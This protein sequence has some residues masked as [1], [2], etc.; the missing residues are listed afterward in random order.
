MTLC[1]IF[2]TFCVMYWSC[3]WITS[4]SMFGSGCEC[5]RMSN[6]EETHSLHLYFAQLN[7]QSFCIDCLKRRLLQFSI[8]FSKF[9]IKR[10][11]GKRW[12]E[13]WWVDM[14]S[15][16]WSGRQGFQELQEPFSEWIDEMIEG[17]R[18]VTGIVIQV[19][20]SL[21]RVREVWQAEHTKLRKLKG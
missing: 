20:Q 3:L 21:R 2:K 19:Q 4:M 5:E 8:L 15:W 7:C 18:H 1:L 12:E 16:R 17:R 13:W 11:W 14:Q 6:L 10:I 9:C